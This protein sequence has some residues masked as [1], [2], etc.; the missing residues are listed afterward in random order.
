MPDIHQFH[1]RQPTENLHAQEHDCGIIGIFSNPTSW[2]AQRAAFLL[3][4]W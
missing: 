4:L 2:G 3:S 1:Y